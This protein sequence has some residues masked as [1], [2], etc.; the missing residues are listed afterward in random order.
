M[1]LPRPQAQED[2]RLTDILEPREM[3]RTE[4]P[5][6]KTVKAVGRGGIFRSGRL[7]MAA[8][9]RRH[10]LRRDQTDRG[11][12]NCVSSLVK[13]WLGLGGSGR[14]GERR[15]VVSGVP[16]RTNFF[17]KCQAA[18][19]RGQASFLCSSLQTING[20]G[21]CSDTQSPFTKGTYI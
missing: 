8:E 6:G 16:P 19:P 17:G 2:V 11:I 5:G 9:M 14:P 12:G 18:S 4:V 20:S 10:A 3:H 7:T 13:F 21:S 15:K 1:L